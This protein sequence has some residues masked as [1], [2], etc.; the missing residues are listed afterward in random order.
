MKKFAL[1][2]QYDGSAF[3]GW[4][5]QKNARTV[6][7]QIEQAL[8]RI[9]KHRVGIIGS[10]R[11]DAGVHALSQYAHFEYNGRMNCDQIT[12]ALNSKLPR[13]IN[14]LE[15]SL[16]N[17]EFHARY[18]A[19]GRSYR[20][21]I[22]RTYSPF[23]RNYK[24][25][26]PLYDPDPKKLNDLAHSLIGQHD[27]TSFARFNP[28]NVSTLC[29]IRICS[30]DQNNNADVIFQIKADHFLHNM[31]RR[32]V[33]TMLTLCREDLDLSFFRKMLDLKD[34]RQKYIYTAPPQGLYLVEVE[35]PRH[36]FIE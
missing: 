15:T 24:T 28:D 34:P 6:Q 14:I 12:R 32:L 3:N 25:F 8:A 9:I 26:L 31:V 29:D 19:L 11:T 33:G 20:Y 35:Y 36:L 5:I 13:D 16:V 4:Q 10:G 2:I 18:S 17:K 27:F 21:V 23:T 30:F 7:D 22:T 1:K